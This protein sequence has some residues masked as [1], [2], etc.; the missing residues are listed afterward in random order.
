MEMRE[1]VC[2]LHLSLEMVMYRPYRT[3]RR[4]IAEQGNGNSVPIQD[5]DI[6]AE[7]E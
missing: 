5:N 4:A 7:L 2:R 1:L 3:A 6:S